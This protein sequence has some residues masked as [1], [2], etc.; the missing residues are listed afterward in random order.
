MLLLCRGGWDEAEEVLRRLVADVPDAGQLTRLTLPTLG[1]LAAR[2]G[3]TEA[4]ALL[5]RA[6]KRALRSDVLDSLAP[7]GLARV[8]WA[9]LTGDVSRADD[10][11]DVLLDRTLT[12]AG[13]PHRGQLMRYMKRAGRQVEPFPGCPEAWAAGL[14]GDWS[15]AAKL[16]GEVGDTYERALELGGSG[17]PA[18][19]AEAL[20]VLD[21]LRAVPAARWVRATLRG[22]GATRVPGPKRATTATDPAGLTARQREVL[23]LLCE[24]LTNVEI[25]ERLVLSVRTVDHHVSAILLKLGAGSRRAAVIRAGELHLVDA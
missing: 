2:R 9:W 4:G 10:A 7:A 22:T 21:R 5:E 12:P 19:A 20:D 23:T 11:I 25:A 8:E 6:W 16:W 18:A 14:R 15:T 24:G 1:R 13:A 3:Y 17:D